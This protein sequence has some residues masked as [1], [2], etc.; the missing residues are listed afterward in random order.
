M[1]S[2][3]GKQIEEDIGGS[4]FKNHII[5]EYGS[6]IIP[7]TTILDEAQIKTL[8]PSSSFNNDPK[9]KIRNPQQLIECFTLLKS[10]LKQN[11]E[12]LPM[13]HWIQSTANT[14]TGASQSFCYKN[15]KCY[16]YG[17]HD[18]IEK[19]EY[20]KLKWYRTEKNDSYLN[21]EWIKA[22]TVI[23][24]EHNRF[25]IN[26]KDWFEEFSPTLD[27]LINFCKA[28]KKNKENILWSIE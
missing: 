25:K 14:W 19:R 4:R 6:D 26:S 9:D 1:A 21:H 23:D 10:Y 24:I 11:R 28:A 27:H 18:V 3:S 15:N 5:L 2:E 7:H 22:D 16:L 20:L 8:T 12:E 17:L 13:A